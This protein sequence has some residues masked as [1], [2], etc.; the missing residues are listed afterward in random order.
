MKRLSET[1]TARLGDGLLAFGLT[2]ALQ[3]LG[4]EPIRA[5][6]AAVGLTLAYRV[7]TWRSR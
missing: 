6:I 3:S 7:L 1:S 2:A 5:I 4:A